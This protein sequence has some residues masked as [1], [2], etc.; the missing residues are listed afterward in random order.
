MYNLDI[1]Q[2]NE[3]CAC[4]RVGASSKIHENRQYQSSLYFGYK[5]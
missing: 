1:L 3:A 5:L 2:F 4:V